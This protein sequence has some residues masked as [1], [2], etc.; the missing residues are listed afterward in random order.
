MDHLVDVGH[1][2]PLVVDHLVDVGHNPA[3][4]RIV[5]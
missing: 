3:D 1:N 4:M 5:Y 2:D